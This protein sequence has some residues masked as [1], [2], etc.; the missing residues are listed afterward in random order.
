M[1]EPLRAPELPPDSPYA[2]LLAVAVE[3]EVATARRFAAK[4]MQ[5]GRPPGDVTDD[6]LRQYGTFLATQMV[7]VKVKPMLRRVVQLWRRA[8]ECN[9]DWPQTPPKLDWEVKLFNPPFSAYRVSLQDEIEAISRWME[10]SGKAGPF[11]KDSRKP[12]RPA[13]IKL[14]LAYVRLI[15]GEHVSLGNEPLSVTSLG[16]LLTPKVIKPILQSIWERGQRRRQAVPEAER[17]PNRNGNTG[18][19]DAAG[20]TLLMLTQY[21]P[22]PPEVLEKIQGLIKKVRKPPMTAM[23]RKNRKRIDQFLDPVKRA[24]LLNLPRVM[25]AEALEPVLAGRG[26]WG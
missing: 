2:P 22:T 21:F 14:R 15:L 23:T 12:L 6:D 1:V 25:M 20:V 19:L 13:T 4:M 17:E 5:Q 11:D 16:D 7:G 24:L 10:G 18:Q 8:A 3:F 9:P 26:S